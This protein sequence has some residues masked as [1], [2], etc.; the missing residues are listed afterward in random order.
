MLHTKLFKDVFIRAKV[1]KFNFHIFSQILIKR[2]ISVL[3]TKNDNET[4][5]PFERKEFPDSYLLLLLR[6]HR[7]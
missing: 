5:F 7:S 4:F 2:I 3:Y 6:L 1:N